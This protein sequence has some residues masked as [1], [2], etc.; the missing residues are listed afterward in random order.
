MTGGWR[1]CFGGDGRSVSPRAIR[2]SSAELLQITV[3]FLSP[4]GCQRSS[5]VR[6]VKY[7][8]GPN[9]H[10]SQNKRGICKDTNL[11]EDMGWLLEVY[12]GLLGALC[13]CRV[14]LCLFSVA[15]CPL[16]VKRDTEQKVRDGR[17]LG[18][19]RWKRRWRVWS[20]LNQQFTRIDLFKTL[21]NY[22]LF[23]WN[24]ALVRGHVA[25]EMMM[26]MM[27]MIMQ[28]WRQGALTI[29]SS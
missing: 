12:F 27:L 14:S 22:Y 19:H 24:E 6:V 15:C 26:M 3:L 8:L 9:P 2:A 18:L 17:I 21:Y 1:R 29:F 23:C 28:R 13:C 7:E 20:L 4:G 10:R 25:D 11:A 5:T 16:D